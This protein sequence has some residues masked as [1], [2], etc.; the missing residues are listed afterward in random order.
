MTGTTK[1]VLTCVWSGASGA[2]YTFHIYALPASFD[3]DQD[4]N[5]IYTRVDE[6]NAWV[7]IYIGEGDLN[8]RSA[9]GHHKAECIAG[10]GATHF[11]CHVNRNGDARLVEEADLLSTYPQAYEPSGCNGRP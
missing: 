1:T 8:E 4:G 2:K 5:Y 6:R 7:P 11:H 3:P 10:K 9:P